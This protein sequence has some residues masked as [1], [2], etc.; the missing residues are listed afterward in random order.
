MKAID[1]RSVELPPFKKNFYN[2]SPE[3]SHRRQA[4]VERFRT[5]KEITIVQVS[6]LRIHFLFDAISDANHPTLFQGHN[7]IGNPITNFEEGGFPEYLLKVERLPQL[8]LQI[9][10]SPS[11]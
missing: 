3:V 9:R 10:S 5:S 2:P 8:I 6:W 1:W 7:K 4:D 11:V